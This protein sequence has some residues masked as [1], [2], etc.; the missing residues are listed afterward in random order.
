MNLLKTLA[1]LA[2]NGLK[3][4]QLGT[5]MVERADDTTNETTTYRV[6]INGGCLPDGEEYQ[7]FDLLADAY[8]AAEDL[9]EQINDLDDDA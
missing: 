1:S 2:P 3:P 5:V 4:G 7:T 8:T 6:W 9:V